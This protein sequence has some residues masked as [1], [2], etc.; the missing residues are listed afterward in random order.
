[1]ASATGSL[2]A[3]AKNLEGMALDN[4]ASHLILTSNSHDSSGEMGIYKQHL[5]VNGC[6]FL[7]GL[8]GLVG[9]TPA[10]NIRV[11]VDGVS[12]IL[13]HEVSTARNY[14]FFHRFNTN[15]KVEVALAGGSGTF[16]LKTLVSYLLD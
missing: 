14:S 12:T 9:S 13:S 2:H 7:T 1:M 5:N 8:N 6:G 4:K 16:T 3:K 15:L 10:A 11:T